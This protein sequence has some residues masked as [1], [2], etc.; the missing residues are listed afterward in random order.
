M[1]SYWCGAL[2]HAQHDTAAVELLDSQPGPGAF[3]GESGQII[4]RKFFRAP[5]EQFTAPRA[6]GEVHGDALQLAARFLPRELFLL[7]REQVGEVP[8]DPSQAAGQGQTVRPGVETGG[9]V[10]DRMHAV[11]LDGGS[12]T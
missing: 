2:S 7:V 9:E 5:L 4:P 10:H 11:A 8:F 1:P 3:T 6:V 12:P